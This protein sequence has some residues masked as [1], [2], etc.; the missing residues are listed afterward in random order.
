MPHITAYLTENVAAIMDVR[1]LLGC[2][3]T[4][5]HETDPQSFPLAGLRAKAIVSECWY[6]ADGNPE[7]ATIHVEMHL[8]AGRDDALVMKVAANILDACEK[9]ARSFAGKP[10]SLSVEFVDMARS[11]YSARSTIKT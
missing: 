3:V 4:A 5:I 7:N 1:G 11:R 6:A 10:L 9:A 2:I 8:L